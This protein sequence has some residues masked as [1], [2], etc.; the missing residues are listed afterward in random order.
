MAVLKQTTIYYQVQKW[1]IDEMIEVLFPM[2]CQYSKTRRL[3]VFS[4]IAGRLEAVA[5]NPTR[6]Q[7]HE[8][9]ACILLNRTI[10]S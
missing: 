4:K 7:I 2:R 1:E 6:R 5:S 9:T 10:F 3:Q 8:T